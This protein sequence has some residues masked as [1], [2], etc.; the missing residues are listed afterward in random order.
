M[1]KVQVN[2]VKLAQY[3]KCLKAM[4]NENRLEILLMIVKNEEPVKTMDMVERLGLRYQTVE[5]HLSILETAGLVKAT[6]APT[7]KEE[8][9]KKKRGRKRYIAFEIRDTIKEKL[10]LHITEGL[11][12]ADQLE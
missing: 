9:R 3:L 12:L 2:E 6:L 1:K 11:K 5:E 8:K 10:I 7:T 4:A